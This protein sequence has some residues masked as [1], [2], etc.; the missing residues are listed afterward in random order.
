MAAMPA[1]PSP[2]TGAERV[3]PGRE[4]AGGR[5]E[6]VQQDRCEQ[7]GFGGGVR[8]RQQELEKLAVVDGLA[9]GAEEARA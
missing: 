9:P 4:D 3:G 1:S 8:S 7:R 2:A 6:G 5:S